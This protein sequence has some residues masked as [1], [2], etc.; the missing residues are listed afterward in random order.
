M[1]KARATRLRAQ[2]GG[3]IC[4]LL[5]V[6]LAACAAGPIPKDRDTDYD[7]IVI[8]GG[9]G[10]LST[11]AH[12]LS[13]GMTVLLLEQHHKVGGCTSSFGRGDFRFDVAL[14]EMAGGDVDSRL[15]EL[16]VAAGV[17]DKI[18]LIR[19]PELYRAVFP[20]LDFTCPG[21]FESAVAALCARWPQER[22]AI[23]AFHELMRNVALD[24]GELQDHFRS[25]PWIGFLR[26]L[27]IPLFQWSLAKSSHDTLGEVLDAHFEDP[28]LK[29]VIAQLW[30]YYG[31]PPDRL[32]APIFLLANHSYL[33]DGAWHVRGSSQALADAYAARIRELGGRIEVG[34]KAVAIPVESGGVRGVRTERGETWSSRYVV[35]SADPFQTF[36]RLV[37][38]EHTPKWLAKKIRG[39]RPSNSF[40]GVYL[41]LDI[42]AAKFWDIDDHEV[43]VNSS[44]DAEAMYQNMMQGRYSEGVASVTFYSNLGDSFY[45]PPGKSV[46]VVHAYSDARVW[47]AEPAAYLLQK[48][49]MVDQ[50]LQ[51][52]GPLMPGLRDHIEVCETVTPLSIQN[53]TMQHGGI[54]YGWAFTVDQWQRLAN[55]TPID[56]LY[57]AGSWSRPSHGV[58]GAQI[59]GYQAA[60]MILDRE[61][62]R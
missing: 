18:E 52:V 57:L 28:G 42:D 11:A 47:S 48:E 25:A 59:S 40:V 30:F 38:E 56:G 49:A 13:K 20:G 58:A 2:L 53:F 5:P 34:T 27:A 61:G 19:I 29:A 44:Y 39:M 14:Q 43:F 9:M 37:G 31:P 10:G 33:T 17:H 15:G 45:A 22:D 7:V 60:R 51:L 24:L 23:I 16:L 32:W 62:R 26:G 6:I 12:L 36:F 50:L 41:G 54:P 1:V 8:G 46:V 3:A 4:C 35:S 21:D 55:D